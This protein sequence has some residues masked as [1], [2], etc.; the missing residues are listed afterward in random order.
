MN[1]T[2]VI[3]EIKSQLKPSIE[4]WVNS[5]CELIHQLKEHKKTS[6]YKELTST[7]HG[8]YTLSASEVKFHHLTDLGYTKAQIVNS[9]TLNDRQIK[10][11]Y[12]KEGAHKL[13]RIDVAVIKKLKD[14]D[15]AT[16]EPL[17]TNDGYD[18]F[19]EGAWTITDVED[20]QHKF[21]FETILAGGYNIQ[22][23]HIR[24]KY[25]LKPIKNANLVL[26]LSE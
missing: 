1:T 16:I 22:C 11:F 8:R 24:V 19:V 7:K 18:G 25:T 12:D 10:E 14:L 20:N 13:A 15:I 26:E 21:A 9:S 6:E 3:E 17:Y 23:L 2:H 5:Q 4:K